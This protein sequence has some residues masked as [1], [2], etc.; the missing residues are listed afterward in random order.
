MATQAI[1]PVRTRS[2]AATSGIVAWLGAAAFVIAATW[3]TLAVRGETVASAPQLGPPLPLPQREHIYYRWLATTLPQE[4]FYTAIAI[5][6]FLCL[7]GTAGVARYRLGRDRIGARI[8]A[9]LVAA[10]AAVWVTGSILQLGGHRAVGL[11]ATHANP[12]QTTNSIAFTID[13]I[14]QAFALAAF[15]LIG[16]RMADLDRPHRPSPG[17]VKG[18]R[19]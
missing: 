3:Y 6:G 14:G 11:M 15:A 16:A 19:Q 2:P 7:G 17:R 13:M 18:V 8:A 12:I 10:G 1:E 4:R 9:F 5:T